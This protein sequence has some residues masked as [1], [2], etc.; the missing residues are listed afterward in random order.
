MTSRPPSATDLLTGLLG[1]ATAGI[2]LAVLAGIAL[3]L[4]VKA[5]M[6]IAA[7]A[8]VMILAEIALFKTQANP[9]T[10]LSPALL[11]PFS[12]ER[13]FRKLIGFLATLSAVGVAYW[14]LSEYQGDFYDP[15]W[16]AL[17]LCVPW[18]LLLSPVYIAYVDRRQ[19][20][21]EDAYAAI[22]AMVVHGRLPRLGH[23]LRQ[24]ILGWIVKAFFLPLM[25][26]YL[27]SSLASVWALLADGSPD[28]LFGWYRTAIEAVYL[29]DV[30]FAA[31]GY[32]VTLRVLDTHIRTVEPTVLGWVACLLCYQPFYAITSRYLPFGDAERWQAALPAWPVLQLAWGTAILACLLIYVW[33]TVCFGLRF[34]NLTHRG[35]ITSGPYRWTKH[36]AYISKNLSWWLVSVPFLGQA[37]F[38]DAMRLSLLLLLVNAIYLLRALTEERHLAWDPDYLAY[39]DFIRREGLAARAVRLLRA[40]P[41]EVDGT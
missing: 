12:A 21:P 36:P 24:H 10:G 14:L 20:E 27:C 40:R 16:A 13:T 30:L 9:S 15:Y 19:V 3:P 34:S 1:A 4:H 2:A 38:S 39:R 17:R 31:I 7:A 32:V 6:I 25:F 29:F 8:A 35:I 23:E 5:L 26:V 28:G 22:G 37:S 33:S 18:I 41:A 11:R